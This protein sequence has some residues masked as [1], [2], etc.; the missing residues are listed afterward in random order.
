MAPETS[1]HPW[2][3]G[4][5]PVSHRPTVGSHSCCEKAALA[6]PR[7]GDDLVTPFFLFSGYKLSVPSPIA[8][9]LKGAANSPLR[10]E[11]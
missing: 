1:S 2:W 3:T 4:D 7:S 6:M 11:H 5:D 8:E 9:L 10:T